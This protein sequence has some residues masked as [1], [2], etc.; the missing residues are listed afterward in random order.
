M[1]LDVSLYC[2]TNDGFGGAA[3]GASSFEQPIKTLKDI[4]A[5]KQAP[6]R[7]SV[8]KEYLLVFMGRI[9]M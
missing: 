4:K 6:E 9:Y 8:R 1:A 5:Q 2:S 7:R 3:G